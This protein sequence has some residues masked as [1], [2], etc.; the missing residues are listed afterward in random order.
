MTRSE[1]DIDPCLKP[2]EQEI[3]T[4]R[5][6]RR[7]L[8][9]EGHANRY[10]LIKGDEVIG[11]WDTQQEA[12]VVGREKYGLV[13]IAVV[14]IDWRSYQRL[15]QWEQQEK[16]KLAMRKNDCLPMQQ[17][18]DTYCRELPRLLT[19]GHSGRFAVVKGDEVISIWD[20]QRDAIQA[21]CERYGL[22]SFGV[23]KIDEYNLQLVRTW[24]AQKKEPSC[25]P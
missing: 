6:E 20:T 2:L 7:R 11:I 14:K 22:E 21:G 24:E 18:F 15:Q 8:L 16:E 17:E 10:A 13:P 3:Q 23:Y 4:Y 12:L 1:H 5:R 9:D 19:E 25:Q